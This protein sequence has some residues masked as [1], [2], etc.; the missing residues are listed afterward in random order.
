MFT[1][2][3][4][5]TFRASTEKSCMSSAFLIKFRVV[6]YRAAALL[7]RWSTKDFF[8]KKDFLYFFKTASF[9]YIS[10]KESGEF[11]L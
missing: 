6:Y 4:I 8:S 10:Q 3:Y 9:W 2:E 11:S 7:R 5:K 1:F